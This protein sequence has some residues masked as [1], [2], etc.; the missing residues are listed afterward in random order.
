MSYKLRKSLGEV[1]KN[2]GTRRFEKRIL[3]DLKR[4]KA[5]APTKQTSIV[6]QEIAKNEVLVWTSKQSR[7]GAKRNS[8]F[9]QENGA[10]VGV[11]L[12][13]AGGMTQRELTF[14]YRHTVHGNLCDV[15][16]NIARR[17]K[18]KGITVTVTHPYVGMKYITDVIFF[19]QKEGCPQNALLWE[20]G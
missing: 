20:F 14:C 7:L 18:K 9:C 19:S 1:A 17:A 16:N 5:E 3:S 11:S 8:F 12:S 6:V 13:V 10:E 15:M 2:F 4:L